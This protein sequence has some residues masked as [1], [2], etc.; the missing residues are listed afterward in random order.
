MTAFEQRAKK[1]DKLVAR[2][3]ALPKKRNEKKVSWRGS[4]SRLAK[5]MAKVWRWMIVRPKIYTLKFP[6]YGA[7]NTNA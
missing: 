6:V 3:L 4:S 2:Y 7:E 1:Y 5:T